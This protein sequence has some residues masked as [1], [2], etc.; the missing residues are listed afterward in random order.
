MTLKLRLLRGEYSI[1]QLPPDCQVPK[2]IQ[3]ED[4]IVI[5]RTEDE[6]SLVIKSHKVPSGLKPNQVGGY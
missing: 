3:W 4:F 6:I 5:V 2:W 1:V